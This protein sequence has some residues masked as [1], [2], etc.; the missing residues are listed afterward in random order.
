[1]ILKPK[2]KLTHNKTGFT[3]RQFEKINPKF[4]CLFTNNF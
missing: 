1:M 3:V 2:K 4:Y